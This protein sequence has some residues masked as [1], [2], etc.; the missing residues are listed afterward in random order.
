MSNYVDYHQTMAQR[1]LDD[2]LNAA[3]R[4]GIGPA[5]DLNF[6][7]ALLTGER[8]RIHAG[9]KRR[10]APTLPAAVVRAYRRLGGDPLL[11]LIA[12]DAYPVLPAG[13]SFDE[14]LAA[15]RSVAPQALQRDCLTGVLHDA[16]RVEALVAGAATL[17]ETIAAIPKRKREWLMHVGLY[18]FDPNRPAARVLARVRD[19][20]EDF[21]DRLARLLEAFWHGAFRAT[22]RTLEPMLQRSLDETERLFAAST[23]AEFAD[24]LRLRVEVNE[25]GGYLEAIRGGARLPVDRVETCWVV[26][27]AFN[28]NRYWYSRDRGGRFTAC[29]PYFD[30]RIGLAP[31]VAARPGVSRTAEPAPDPALIFKALGNATRFAMAQLVARRPRPAAELAAAL[32]LSKPTISHHVHLLREAGLLLETPSGGAVVLSLKMPTLQGLSELTLQALYDGA[33]PHALEEINR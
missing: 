22:W 8:G 30:A 2:H 32:S 33:R 25:R 7:L 1:S 17:A 11:W 20:P 24:A 6:A 9:W 27:S 14:S 15:L 19:D 13:L 16:R 21:R 5:F 12:A 28:E 31:A 10:V 29:F 18:P 23:F 26:P 4:F 3:V